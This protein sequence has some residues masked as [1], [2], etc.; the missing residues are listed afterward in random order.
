M[1][2]RRGSI[3][4]AEVRGIRIGV[5][6]SWFIVLFL[7]IF[8][9]SEQFRQVLVSSDAVAY[10]TSVLAALFFFASIV[11]HEL[12][13]AWAARR[14]GF[15]V[16]R[17]D[18]WFFGGLATMGREAE[19]PAEELKVALAG[20][21]VTL[22]VTLVCLGLAWGIEGVS[23]L[24]H[25][26]TLSSGSPAA[27]ALVLLSF[28]GLLNAALL[29]FNLLPTLPLDG[30]RIA[31]ALIWRRTGDKVAATRAAA[32]TGVWIG[33]LCGACGIYLFALGYL[34]GLW[35][36]AMAF[37]FAQ[38][39]R[40]AVAQTVFSERIDGVRVADIMDTEPVSV[41]D[42]ISLD[43]ALNEYFLRYRWPWF[44]VVDDI[45]R[46]V[47]LVREEHVREGGAL[48]VGAV[49]E[50]AD[51]ASVPADAPLE[52][53]IAS[54]PLR[55]LGTLMAIDERGV[56]RGVVSVDQLRRALASAFGAAR[57]GV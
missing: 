6:A 9:L 31:R 24:W 35:L 10:L 13:H 28:V 42:E 16:T 38:A 40:A 36:V 50:R 4:L 33:W 32:R 34:Y 47:G 20:P 8:V 5:D 43:R 30:G 37:V 45:G 2:R 22:V 48:T 17:I 3:K 57:P 12:G 39:S 56:L 11:L 15:E 55:R 26:A 44:P 23:G 21:L 41:P 52:A 7:V 14:E 25:A 1:K 51:D 53:L 29:I 18:L 19:T 27:P 46:Y 49:L 54:E